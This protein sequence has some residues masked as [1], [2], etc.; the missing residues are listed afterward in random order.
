MRNRPRQP[1]R[2][3][4]SLSF[5]R[6]H[7]LVV[8][9]SPVRMSDP[10]RAGEVSVHP[11]ADVGPELAGLVEGGGASV[12]EGLEAVGDGFGLGLGPPGVVVG[13]GHD[14]NRSSTFE[15]V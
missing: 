9:I 5:H 2:M 13:G 12:E 7:V 4:V 15:F 14:A 10:W 11:G 6:C 3:R 8:P 1:R